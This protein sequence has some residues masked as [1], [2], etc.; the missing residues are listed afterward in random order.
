MVELFCFYISLCQMLILTRNLQCCVTNPLYFLTDQRF[1]KTPLC[2]F[3]RVHYGIT[4]SDG[5][6]FNALLEW[7]M[8]DKKDSVKGIYKTNYR[9]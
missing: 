1:R 4:R 2:D 8:F 6:R 5:S 9:Q 7:A 3:S